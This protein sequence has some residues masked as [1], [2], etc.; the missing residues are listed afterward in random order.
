M[1]IGYTSVDVNLRMS[2]H[3]WRAFTT[4]KRCD[5]S[6]TNFHNAILKYGYNSFRIEV[7]ETCE[8]KIDAIKIENMYIEKYRG[9]GKLYNQPY[10]HIKGKFKH[11]DKTKRKLSRLKKGKKLSR[12]HCEAISTG[13]LGKS[14]PNIA[15]AVKKWWK[16]RKAK[17]C[18]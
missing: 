14:Q 6:N 4:K 12:R 9:N 15:K 1:Y 16:Q 3:I 2:R 7:L 11:T 5:R 8:D 17:L 10:G 13:K 18:H